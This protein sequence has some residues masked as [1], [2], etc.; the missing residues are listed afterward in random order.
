MRS[1]YREDVDWLRAIAVFAVIAFHF[2]ALAIS[3]Y[4]IT[5]II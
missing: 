1:H 3:G 4:L 2:E 5:E